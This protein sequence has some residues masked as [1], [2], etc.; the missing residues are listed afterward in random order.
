VLQLGISGNH[1]EQPVNWKNGTVVKGVCLSL[2][3]QLRNRRQSDLTCRQVGCHQSGSIQ[4]DR[5]L[6][7]SA[8]EETLPWLIKIIAGAVVNQSIN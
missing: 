7:I 2:K 6:S 8:V 5:T 3:Y 4:S 1:S